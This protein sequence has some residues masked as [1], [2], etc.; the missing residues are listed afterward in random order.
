[1]SPQGA[2]RAFASHDLLSTHQTLQGKTTRG[3]ADGRRIAK[4][5]SPPVSLAIAALG[6]V[7]GDIGT[8]PLYAAN[9]IFGGQREAL[10]PTPENARGFA[11]LVVWTLTLVVT[12][13]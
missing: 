9:A 6:V 1:M 5:S 10:A 13:K 8:S 7:Y 11:S 4:R 2:I 12:L 3:A